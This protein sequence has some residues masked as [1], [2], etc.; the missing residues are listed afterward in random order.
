MLLETMTRLKVVPV[1]RT[2][3]EVHAERACEWLLE[4]GCEAIEVTM[5]VPNAA[6][7]ISRLR[8]RTPSALVGAG[9]VLDG[10]A[11]TIVIDAGASFVVS[12]C[13]A[14][15]AAEVCAARGVPFLPGAATPSEILARWREGAV[16]VKVFPAHQL[17][18][19]AFV[20]A[21]K[22]VFPNIPLMPTGGVKPEAVT[23]Y[24]SAGACCVGMGSELAPVSALES[25]DKRAVMRVAEQVLKSCGAAA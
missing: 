19:P 7:L 14:P 25:G 24:L 17:G 4:A 23:S 1:I 16:I 10:N 13:A 6:G 9:T 18:G 15:S 8:K 5:T 2:T 22:A 11:A 3:S 20:K 21:M 12:P